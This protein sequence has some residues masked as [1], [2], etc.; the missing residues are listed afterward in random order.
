MIH[1]IEAVADRLDVSPRQLRRFWSD[2]FKLNAVDEACRPGVNVS[3]N[4][5]RLG[6]SGLKNR[7]EEPLFLMR[8]STLK[9]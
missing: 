6:I 5:R 3:A 1:M 4:A 9:L 8:V 7:H 2:S